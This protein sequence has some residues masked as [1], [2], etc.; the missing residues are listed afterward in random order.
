MPWLML[1]FLI[2]LAVLGPFVGAD[3]RDGHRRTIER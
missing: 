2:A 3:S 1:A